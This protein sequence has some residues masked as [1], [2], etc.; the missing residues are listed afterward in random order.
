MKEKKQQNNEN[1]EGERIAKRIAAAGVCSRR[2]AEKLIEEGIVK[3]NGKVINT[4]AIKVT[5]S[6][7]I[8]IEGHK[9]G[10]KQRVRLFLYHKPKGLVTTNK[11]E[12]GRKTIFDKLPDNLPRV[13]TVGRLDINTEG[14]LLLTTSGELA[15]HLEL[16]ASE[17]P[18][19]YRVR[20]FGKISQ[21]RLDTLKEGVKIEGVKY[22][23]IVAELESQ[24]GGNS[25][26]EVTLHEGK[27]R[28][29]RKVMEYLGLQVNRLIRISYGEFELGT[30]KEG[31]A[32]EISSDKLKKM[33]G[34]KF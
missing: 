25:W 29:I 13:V 20:A 6:D 26:I 33:F 32:I 4:P 8:E 34:D 3:L 18:R 15:R 16:P 17:V 9:I 22:A 5:D 30:I 10:K 28:E 27:N 21:E 19:K 11:D 24:Q 7:E 23:P 2:D 31:K 1:N 12:R 14:L